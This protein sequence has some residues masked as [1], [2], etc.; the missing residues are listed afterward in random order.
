MSLENNNVKKLFKILSCSFIMQS[1]AT[2]KHTFNYNN[3][4]YVQQKFNINY[5]AKSGK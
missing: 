1:S 2:N 3:Y 4:I 5:T